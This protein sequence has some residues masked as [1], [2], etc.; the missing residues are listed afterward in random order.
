[1]AVSQN[2]WPVDR[3]GEHQ[4]RAPIV[5]GVLV[6]NGVLK[7]DVAVVLRYVAHRFHTEVEPLHAGQ[8]WGWYVKGIE[9]GTSISNHSSGT[10]IDLNAPAHPLAAAGTFS[11]TQRSAIRRI[12]DA[13]DGVVR[14]GGDYSGRKDEMHW[15]IVKGA[16]AV[17]ALAEKISKPAVA[18]APATTDVKGSSMEWTDRPWRADYT[19]ATALQRAYLLADDNNEHLKALEA[20]VKAGLDATGVGMHALAAEIHALTTDPADLANPE[21]HPLVKVIR[22]VNAHSE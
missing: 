14:W 20:A 19:A 9:G 3:T 8:C 21:D 17:S 16:G 13:C 1:M 7:G 12:L 2:G 22:W 6:P 4:D 5:P 11:A 15:E 10:A 18:P